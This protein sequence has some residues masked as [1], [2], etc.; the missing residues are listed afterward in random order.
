MSRGSAD[1]T[2]AGPARE[3]AGV[4]ASG[5][6]SRLAIFIAAMLF[7][8]SFLCAVSVASRAAEEIV[9]RLVY[10]PVAVHWEGLR[11]EKVKPGILVSNGDRLDGWSFPHFLITT[12]IWLPLFWLLVV[13]AWRRLPADYRER[14]PVRRAD[15]PPAP[16]SPLDAVSLFAALLLTVVL[17]LSVGMGLAGVTLLAAALATARLTA[18]HRDGPA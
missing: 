7:Y 3:E 4:P 17:V 12:A 16:G 18:G 10:G 5:F 14:L 9:L 6:R 13:T 8:G 1:V 2:P 11:F 15:D